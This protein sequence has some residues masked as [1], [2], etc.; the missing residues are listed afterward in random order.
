M[1]LEITKRYEIKEQTHRML[2]LWIKA[3]GYGRPHRSRPTAVSFRLAVTLPDRPT[4][5]S[6]VRGA[7]D[8]SDA[9]LATGCKS[10]AERLGTLKERPWS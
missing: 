4:I 10:R 7:G 3:L 1:K 5:V 2:Y 9:G 8:D 6:G